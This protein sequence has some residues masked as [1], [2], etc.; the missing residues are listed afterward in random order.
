[1][2]HFPILLGVHVALAIAL[3]APSLLL[4]FALG[5]RPVRALR[6]PGRMEGALASFGTRGAPAVGVALAVT[7]FGLV[8]LLG[9]ELLRQPWLLAALGF[10]ALCLA[11]AFFVQRP[12]VRRLLDRRAAF[13][14]VA[15]VER[16]RRQRYVAYLMAAL[17]GTIGFLMSQKPALW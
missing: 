2:A 17:V 13:D 10:Y 9:P 14:E 8:A 12:G 11:L 3:L 4:P 1:M 5:R 15:W 16:A 7:G 6:E